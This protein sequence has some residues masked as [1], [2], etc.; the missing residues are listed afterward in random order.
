MPRVALPCLAALLAL[1]L[2]AGCSK[3]SVEERA[4][5]QAEKLQKEMA[6][7]DAAALEQKVDPAIVSDVQR[8]LTTLKEYQGEIN[9]VIDGVTVNAIEAFQRAAGLHDDGLITDETRTKL[10]AAAQAAPKQ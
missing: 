6:D 8:Q 10:A 9:G 5:V 3:E 2:A 4:R 7:H 1:A